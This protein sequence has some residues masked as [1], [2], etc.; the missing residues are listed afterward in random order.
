MPKPKRQESLRLYKLND[1]QLQELISRLQD[2]KDMLQKE[3]NRKEH[4]SDKSIKHSIDTTIKILQKQ[5]DSI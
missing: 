4:F 3:F 5:L 1:T 2:I